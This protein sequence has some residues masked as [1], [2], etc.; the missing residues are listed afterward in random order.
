MKETQKKRNT[1]FGV[2]SSP[3]GQLPLRGPGLN[4]HDAHAH[5]HPDQKQHEQQ[6]N[7]DQRSA[8]IKQTKKHGYLKIEPPFQDRWVGHQCAVWANQHPVTRDYIECEQLSTIAFEAAKNRYID[9]RYS[10]TPTTNVILTKKHSRKNW[11]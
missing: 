4:V 1:P 7:S 6:H 8:I 11:G 3:P 9:K 5:D 10:I 2:T